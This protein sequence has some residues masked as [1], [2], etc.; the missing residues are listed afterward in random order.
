MNSDFYTTQ[1]S[2][3]VHLLP[4]I[5]TIEYL[6]DAKAK[7]LTINVA[8]NEVRVVEGSEARRIYFDVVGMNDEAEPIVVKLNA[9][10]TKAWKIPFAVFTDKTRKEEVK[11]RRQIIMWWLRSS[12]DFSYRKIGSYF[13]NFDHSTVLHAFNRI[14]GMRTTD[15]A[16]KELLNDFE[17]AIKD[18]V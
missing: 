4:G 9:A 1:L 2:P 11:D 16:I 6:Y 13:G 5:G 12:T 14:E 8:N 15:A 10:C 7:H 18:L 3:E 17:T